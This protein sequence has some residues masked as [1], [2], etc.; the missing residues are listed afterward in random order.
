MAR[1]KDRTTQL[2]VI[3]HAKEEEIGEDQSHDFCDIK[4][5]PGLNRAAPVRTERTGGARR[6]PV[7]NSGYT[8]A[9]K[10]M[11][12]VLKRVIFVI[13][14]YKFVSKYA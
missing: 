14:I 3:H 1:T 12:F 2:L 4:R 10:R 13:K 9:H 5:A 6:R 7:L 11:F 8:R